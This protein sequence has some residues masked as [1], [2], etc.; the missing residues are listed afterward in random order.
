TDGAAVRITDRFEHAVPVVAVSDAGAAGQPQR[1][2]PFA[3][4]VQAE[5]AARSVLQPLQ[6]PACITVERDVVLVRRLDSSE[7]PL[8]VESKDP[9]VRPAPRPGQNCLEVFVDVTIGRRL[10]RIADPLRYTGIASKD[11]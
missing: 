9:P 1:D 6:A 4:V 5:R 7:P 2:E 10:A 11:D 3:A 8:Q